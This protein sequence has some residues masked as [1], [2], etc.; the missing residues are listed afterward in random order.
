M[1]APSFCFVSAHAIRSRE[2]S[3]G[4]KIGVGICGFLGKVRREH[5]K[6]MGFTKKR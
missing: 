1:R 6:T 2:L 3:E 4:L 5:A